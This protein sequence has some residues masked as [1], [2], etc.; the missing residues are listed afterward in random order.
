MKKILTMVAVFLVAGGFIYFLLKFIKSESNTVLDNP[1]SQSTQMVLVKANDWNSMMGVLQLYERATVNGAWVKVGDRMGASL[2]KNGL[3]WGIGLHGK[4]LT[5]GPTVVEGSKRSPV[6]VFALQSVF[7][8]DQIKSDV[9]LSYQQVTDTTFC[10]DDPN[11][12]YY[13]RIVDSKKVDKDWGSAEDMY[14]YMI[15]GVYAYGIVIEHNYE[16]PKPGLGSCFFF[17]VYRGF[18]MPTAGCTAVSLEQIEKIITWL[19]PHKKPILVQLPD[20]V[21]VKFQQQWNLP[22]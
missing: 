9:K 3:G 22:E 4:A 15:D 5:D 10:P 11:S 7:G 8:R 18:G 21:F 19:D 13:N 2:G 20:A 12:K 16:R 17:H 1:T 14:K 6:G